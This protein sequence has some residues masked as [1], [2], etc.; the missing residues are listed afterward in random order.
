VAAAGPL[1]ALAVF[2]NYV[3]RGVLPTAASLIKDELHLSATQFGLLLSAF[4]WSYTPGQVLAAWLA[5]RI[6]PYRTLG[7]GLAV[8][9]L[10][11][12]A[13]GLAGGFA[14]LMGLRLV[15]GL[16]E[17]AAFPCSA[18]LLAAGLPTARLG[19]ANGLIGVGLALGPAFGTFVGGM[20][21]AQLGWRPIFI[22]FGLVSLLWLA[23]WWA[24]SRGAPSLAARAEAPPPAFSE[25]LSRPSLWGASLG[26]FCNNYFFYFVISWLP[27]YL[28]KSRG[29]SLAEM[30]KIGGLIYVV[31]AISSFLVGRLTDRWIAARESDT[32]PRKTALAVG[33]GLTAIALIVCAVSGRDLAVA[34]LFCAGFAFGFNTPNIYA[35]GQTLAGPRAAAKWMGIQNGVANS[36]GIVAPII[37]GLVVDATGQFLWAFLIAAG[38]A[39]V[40][41]AGWVLM[42][43]KIAPI[44]WET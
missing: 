5:D 26:Q 24:V 10:A 19:A 9:S 14:A 3:D 20:A 17:S 6:G 30:A 29:F 36:A 31:F 23:P 2:I 8:W 43:D 27:L 25:L 11:T 15:L 21:M 22:G 41:I 4:F 18:K 12:A 39:L 7:L 33:H 40:G 44:A 13:S 1:L 38:V 35:T 34:C 16:G 37:T 42:I 28:V 32:L